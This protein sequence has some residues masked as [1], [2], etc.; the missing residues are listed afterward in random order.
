MRA[1][2]SVVLA[3]ALIACGGGGGGGGGEPSAST[4][5]LATGQAGDVTV[6]LLAAGGLREGQTAARVRLTAGG[7]P[8]AGA[9]VT[10]AAR[11]AGEGALPAVVVLG[12]RETVAGVQALELVFPAPGE[13]WTVSVEVRRAGAAP[14]SVD[15]PGLP[16]LATGRAAWV[17]DV[18]VTLG[19]DRT[20]AVGENPVTVTLHRAIAG[21]L[22]PV[23]DAAVALDPEMP[24]MGHG[25]P[26][27]VAPALSDP[28]RY[29]GTVAFTMRGEWVVTATVRE[30]EV[31]LG[32][33]DLPVTF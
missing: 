1:S 21:A 7:A 2:P 3:A 23:D 31:S 4:D 20:P 13:G 19:F 14:V 10:V 6:E 5:L 32:R 27:G 29:R 28:G 12:P 8:V 25:A 33:A 30:G 24:S 22:S 18:L 11:P 17:G 9:A 16:V 15:L 26:P